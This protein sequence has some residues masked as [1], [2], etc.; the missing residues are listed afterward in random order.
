MKDD[1]IIA[2]IDVIIAIVFGAFAVENFMNGEMF[3]GA[4][5]VAFLVL[6]CTYCLSHLQKYRKGKE[7]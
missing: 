3:R 6:N 2:I 1:L 4:I 5:K 7:K